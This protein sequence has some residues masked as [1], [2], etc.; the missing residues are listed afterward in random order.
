VD[1]A[2]VTRYTLTWCGRFSVPF[3]LNVA[4]R[5]SETLDGRPLAGSLLDYGT[6]LSEVSLDLDAVPGLGVTAPNNL[7][8]WVGE[9]PE[10]I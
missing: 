4:R 5:V 10:G 7:H 6:S 3:G 9:G 2:D 8:H 1:S